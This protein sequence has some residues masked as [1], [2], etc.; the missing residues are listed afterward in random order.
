[1][2]DTSNAR[3]INHRGK[4]SVYLNGKRYSLGIDFDPSTEYE[5]K[6]LKAIWLLNLAAPVDNN[7]N[8]LITAYIDDLRDEKRDYKRP[9]YAWKNLKNTFAHLTPDIIDKKT[10]R[11]YIEQRRDVEGCA[12]D[13]IRTEMSVLRRTINWAV[14]EKLITEAD[15]S[16]II[17]PKAGAPREKYLTREQFRVFLAGAKS[18]HVELFIVIAMTSA[19][20]KQAILQLQWANV[21]FN[22]R[23]I[24]FRDADQSAHRKGRAIVPMNDLVFNALMEA[25]AA[26]QGDYVIEYAGG[27]VGN[28]RHSLERISKA[29]GVHASAHIFRHSAAVWM[30]QDN[31][32]IQMIAEYLGHSDISI[33][34]KYYAR[35]MP[36][37]LQD[38]ADVLT[39]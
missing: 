35:Y 20:R 26:R 32:P 34:Y 22:E 11:A 7:I 21:K 14:K 29:T 38:A 18:P 33:T 6:R 17:V 15:K 19:A 10:Q 16:H 23:Q 27:P 2:S 28:I 36:D 13:T 8:T 31:K 5:A 30:A 9:S 39:W 3:L 25:Y 1:M 24:D 12:Q 4:W 37:H